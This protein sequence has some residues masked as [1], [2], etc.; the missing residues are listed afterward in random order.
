MNS[1]FRKQYLVPNRVNT[2]KSSPRYIVTKLRMLKGKKR[3][4][5]GKS[6]YLRRKK[7]KYPADIS[8]RKTYNA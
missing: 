4:I 3:Q 2:N 7:V 8:I 6:E 1:Q 5:K